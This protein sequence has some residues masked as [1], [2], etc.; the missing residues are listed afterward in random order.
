LLRSHTTTLQSLR[1]ELNAIDV[2]IRH[3]T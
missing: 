3:K 1:A 2:R